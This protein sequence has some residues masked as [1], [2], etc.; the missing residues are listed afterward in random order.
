MLNLLATTGLTFG[1]LV[2]RTGVPSVALA[3]GVLYRY[4]VGMQR[5]G[6]VDLYAAVA[7]GG[8]SWPHESLV[9]MGHH[10]RQLA[11]RT[12]FVPPS[13]Q[14]ATLGWTTKPSPGPS[15]QAAATLLY[16]LGGSV[17]QAVGPPRAPRK[18]KTRRRS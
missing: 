15:L 12:L 7:L 16:G 6:F 10:L 14:A 1:V 5:L 4:H 17:A 3:E 13:P 2:L 9:V 8:D 18:G 11:R